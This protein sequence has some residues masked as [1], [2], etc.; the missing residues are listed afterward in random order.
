MEA[1]PLESHFESLEM[2]RPAPKLRW[3][4]LLLLGL[5]IAAPRGFAQT[6]DSQSGFSA[7][8]APQFAIADFDGDHKPDL[9]TVEVAGVDSLFERYSIHIHFSSG[10]RESVAV[11]AAFGGLQI[12][13]RDVNGDFATDLIVRSALMHQPVA[14]LLNDGHGNFTA[15]SPAAFLSAVAETAAHWRPYTSQACEAAPFTS[16][17]PPV[18]DFPQGLFGSP[19]R[20]AQRPSPDFWAL[21]YSQV[22]LSFSGR[23][24]P[25]SSI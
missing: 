9:A 18:R 25:I 3:I 22:C 7:A 4:W 16:T 21:S 1:Q 13:P 14:V 24:P 12:I 19:L 2:K 8:P 20:Q 10:L 23:A 5:G 17:Q 11:S 6:R 15:E